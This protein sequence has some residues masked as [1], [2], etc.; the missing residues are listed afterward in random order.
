[1]SLHFLLGLPYNV[2][3]EILEKTYKRKLVEAHPDRSKKDT[4][5]F[6]Y[7]IKK[8]YLDHKENLIN[9]NFFLEC[10]VDEVN[11]IVCRCGTL[12]DKSNLVYDKVEC[13]TCSCFVIVKENLKY[14]FK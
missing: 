7:M 9:E 6:Y 11:I 10:F 14:I 13:E 5:D 3:E 12:F 1:M 2:D 4:K 8:A